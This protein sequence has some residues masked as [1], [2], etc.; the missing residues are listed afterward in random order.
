M[1]TACRS[2]RRQ[3]SLVELILILA[4]A[5]VDI[6]AAAPARPAALALSIYP[7]AALYQCFMGHHNEKADSGLY[8]FCWIVGD[9][10]CCQFQLS[11]YIADDWQHRWLRRVVRWRY[12]SKLYGG[13]VLAEHSNCQFVGHGIVYD[14]RSGLY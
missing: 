5:Q 10:T 6:T 2:A 8:S 11:R 7:L 9:G 12:G 14:R 1:L 4:A 13:R 3:T